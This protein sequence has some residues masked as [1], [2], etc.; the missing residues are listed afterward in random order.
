MARIEFRAKIQTVYEFNGDVAYQ[1]VQVPT[2]TRSHCDMGA[3]RQ[4]PK[5]GGYAN[6]DLFPGMLRHIR[7]NRFPWSVN[8]RR[9]F[10]IDDVPTGVTLDQSGFLARV[11]FEA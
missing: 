5:Y 6:S 1:Y 4:H 10:K 9:A 11:T 7:D 8:G 2:L 3:F